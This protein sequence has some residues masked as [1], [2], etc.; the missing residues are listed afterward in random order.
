MRLFKILLIIVETLK[1]IHFILS[2][3]GIEG[4]GEGVFARRDFLPGDL[5]LTFMLFHEVLF[6]IIINLFN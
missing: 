3:S 5:G 4:G 2:M 6:S 1:F